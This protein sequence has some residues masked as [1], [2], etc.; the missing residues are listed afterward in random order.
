MNI[1][2]PLV[3][4]RALKLTLIATMITV[5][6]CEK[7][8]LAV[9]HYVDDA[10]APYFEAFAFEGQ[11]RGVVVN[12]KHAQIEGYLEDLDGTSGQCQHFNDAP[13]RV[14]IDPDYWRRL[15]DLER[16]FIIFH[17]LG[18]CFLDRSHLDLKN[19][20]GTCTSMMHSSASACVN[21]YSAETR[22]AYLDELFS[23]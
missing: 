11:L 21:A 13:D 23:Y 22:D 5:S 10:M 18:H 12:F 20:D 17:E 14:V 19:D 15:N 4:S 2:P 7:E 9:A 16:E 6:S 3:L 1:L 8:P